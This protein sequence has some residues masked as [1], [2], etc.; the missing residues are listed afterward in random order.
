MNF[1]RLLAVVL[2]NAL[3]SGC[4]L[5]AQL[6]PSPNR[7][8]S[9][10]QVASTPN[11]FN[12]APFQNHIAPLSGPVRFLFS[13]K[14]KQMAA[15]HPNVRGWLSRKG[16][17]LPAAPKRSI[18]PDVTSSDS[19]ATTQAGTSPCSN[20]TGA[21]FNLEPLHGMRE[22]RVPMPQN[23]TPVDFIP[24][25]GLGG[26]DLVIGGANDYRGIIEPEV[27]GF[28]G[29]VPPHGW[30]FSATGYYVHRSG[31][32]CGSDFEGGLPHL[33][34][35]PT[36]ETLF[37]MGDP[38]IAVDAKRNL[39]Y[40]ADL[41]F[42]YT[43][44]GIG[45]FRTTAA[46]LN[47]AST[48][49]DGTHLTDASGND[50]VSAG[51]WPASMLL[52]A[53]PNVGDLDDKPH[54]RV[55]ERST[56]VGAGDI[57]LTYTW[58]T[59]TAS[60]INLVTCPA[61]FT[62]ILDCSSPQTI[63]H[64]NDVSTQFSHISVR[65]DGVIT[66]SYV[67]FEVFVLPQGNPFLVEQANI[68]LVTCTP[69]GAPNPPTCSL[70]SVVAQEKQPIPFSAIA[71]QGFRMD[72]YPTHDQRFNPATGQYEEFVV[73]TRCAVQGI[74]P[75][76]DGKQYDWAQCP[77]TK[78]AMSYSTAGSGA[79]IKWSHP[80]AL[81]TSPHDQFF[82]WVRTD[83]EKNTVQIIYYSSENDPS[84]HLLQVME[85]DVVPG[86]YS[87]SSPQVLTTTQFNPSADFVLGDLDPFFGDYIGIAARQGHAYVHFTGTNF[88]GNFGGA[89]ISGQN[90]QLTSFSY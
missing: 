8:I 64:P 82:P 30:G 70:P 36:N 73:W 9:R 18:T 32:G 46:N 2:L 56:G 77:E 86:N 42:G 72:T 48:C 49:P 90:N 14:A 81:D 63:S 5:D 27:T 23:E 74:F 3:Y 16:V 59:S 41:R 76:G 78:V 43:V 71:E 58:F 66:I 34:Y 38:V 61:A 54:L 84:G 45:L 52:A 67:N 88:P 25:G 37:G 35:S 89:L 6:T 44:S 4:L 85:N 51:C 15:G 69:N 40:A 29:I 55:D 68:K 11:P 65:P 7:I 60:V 13:T 24:G 62:S 17:S 75:V 57:Y 80:V 79:E 33:V 1:N 83:H 28:S 21:K 39:V 10:S 31:S 20:S 22:I 26:S 19:I 50:T 53:D 12:P 47:S 87:A